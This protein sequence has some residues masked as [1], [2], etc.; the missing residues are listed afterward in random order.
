[1]CLLLKTWR[2][3][4]QI[5]CKF[6]ITNKAKRWAPRRK[7]LNEKRQTPLKLPKKRKLPR[8]RWPRKQLRLREMVLKQ[9]RQQTKRKKMKRSKEEASNSSCP[10]QKKA[11]S[12]RKFQMHNSSRRRRRRKASKHNKS[13]HPSS[14]INRIPIRLKLKRDKTSRNLIL[15]RARQQ[16]VIT[17]LLNILELICIRKF[18]S[19]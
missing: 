19:L 16:L 1:M 11:M 9:K 5:S 10:K 2:Q 4:R 7:E 14:N 15:G 12:R 18:S 13:C 8:K 17:T 3:V 6:R